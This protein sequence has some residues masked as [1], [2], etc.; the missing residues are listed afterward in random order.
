MDGDLIELL[1]RLERISPMPDDDSPELTPDL[2][3][4]YEEAIQLFEKVDKKSKYYVQAQ[5][6]YGISYVHFHRAGGANIL[7]INGPQ[8]INAVVVQGNPLDPEYSIGEGRDKIAEVSKK[9]FRL[10]DTYGVE[11]EPGADDVLILAAT[12]AVDQLCHDIN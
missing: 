3:R 9:W 1:I 2:L 5:F 8:V 4:E 6:F 11:I 10:R 7:P 12:V